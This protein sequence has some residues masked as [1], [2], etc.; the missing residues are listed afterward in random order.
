MKFMK[1]DSA[2]G[3]A[4]A[5]VVTHLA[6]SH[7]DVSFKFI[8]DGAELLHTPGDGKLQS[9]VYAAMGRDFAP[10]AHT[11][12]GARRRCRRLRLR[13]KAPLRQRHAQAPAVLRERP[14]RQEPAALRR[15]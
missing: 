3:T 12:R 11:G 9:A 15:A 6:L 13:D 5:G 7:P 8:R 1:K 10:R 2:E 4:V 14:L